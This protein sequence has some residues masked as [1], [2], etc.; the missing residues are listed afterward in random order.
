[1]MGA[2]ESRFSKKLVFVSHGAQQMHCIDGRQK[3]DENHSAE[4]GHKGEAQSTSGTIGSPRRRFWP[5]ERH[6]SGP[7][8]SKRSHNCY[9]VLRLA[10]VGDSI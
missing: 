1:M 6:H 2:V 9:P 3:K 8:L 5:F 10:N 7:S 4:T